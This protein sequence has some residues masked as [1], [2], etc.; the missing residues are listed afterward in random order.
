MVLT[1]SKCS[2]ANPAE[3][4]Y[5]YYDGFVLGGGAARGGPL[6]V[7]AQPFLA[8]FVFPNGR[9]CR[10]FDEMAVACQE[11]WPAARDL[12]AQGFL[13]KF[14]GGLGRLDLALA[15]K[16]AAH[17]PDPDRGL[18]QLLGKLPSN[19]LAEPALRVEPQELNLGALDRSRER[20]FD[21]HLD[22][23]GMRL[24]YGS[25]NASEGWL[26]LGEGEGTSEKHF[27]FTHEQ[28]IPV[29]I[30]L[31]KLRAGTKPI[32]GKLLVESNA[33][34]TVVLVRATVPIKPF[35]EGVLKGA[36]TPRQVAEKAKA[37]PK[38]AA[39]LFEHGA[40]AAWYKDNGWTYPVQ[41]PAASG[42]A[43]V[44]QFFEALGLTKPP[45][46]QISERKIA[47]EGEPGQSLRASLQVSTEE[48]RAVYAHGVSDQPWLEVGRAKLNGRV[49]T[50]Q[51]TIPSVPNRPGEAL[52]AKLT[53]QSNGNQRFVVPVTLQVGGS[54]AA[55]VFD[56]DAMTT[57][58]APTPVVAPPPP[59]VA[60]LAP[61]PTPPP[62]APS[63]SVRRP[64]DQRGGGL[65]RHLVPAAVLL[66]ALAGIVVIDLVRKPSGHG[67]PESR[68]GP[69]LNYAD[70]ADK[71]AY[72]DYV[73][74]TE[75]GQTTYRFGL[76][77][78]KEPDPDNPKEHKRL[79]YRE[80]GVTN[81]TCV[82][83]AGHEYIFG[84]KYSGSSLGRTREDR[85]KHYWATSWT[86][87]EK[88]DVLQ[89]VQIV[90]GAQ[91]GKLD[92]ALV[93]YT[94]HNKGR[95]SPKVGLRVMFD[96]YIGGNDRVPFVIPGKP[97]MVKTFQE[98]KGDAIPDYIEALEKP[99]PQNPGTVAHMGLKGIHVP[100]VTV[101]P[102]D[103]VVLRKFPGADAGWEPPV[104][105][106][107][108][109]LEIDDSCIML[110][111]AEREMDFDEKRYMA[112]SYGLNAISSP[113]G[114]GNLALTAGGSFLVGKDFTVTAYV[115]NPQARETVTLDLP[116]GLS[117]A[118]G[119]Q[120]E[121]EVQAKGEQTQVSWKVVHSSDQE[122]EYMI[123]AHSNK[124][125][126]AGYRVRITKGGLFR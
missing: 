78:T 23:S 40:V 42:K 48:S 49:A 44:Q 18:D 9:T 45:K 46:V 108:K 118:S 47:L 3:A 126:R 70:L 43:A 35:P 65:W 29:R 54:A 21:L 13:E 99:D 124:G 85:E 91:S 12:L 101:E 90:P 62:P 10:S 25:V 15:A 87:P 112:F 2:R 50:L 7:G 67:G 125:A 24:V 38:E 69:G 66:L 20:A 81:N 115:K 119:Q 106:E 123:G 92:T 11:E 63:P 51:F 104:P 41:G 107:V 80:N 110:Y 103:R 84:R 76:I 56:F 86:S 72:L 89:E 95:V 100:D 102:I 31:D 73:P 116:E 93:R 17:F 122:G 19:V 1:C 32:E 68:T 97:G 75:S 120:A 88:V 8:P 52:K 16:E 83:I 94:L 111:W 4:V 96:T 33:G 14:L 5:C 64:R 57:A 113:E 105:E 61:A 114:G 74:S 36:L 109:A 37:S 98:I 59:P 6:A 28:T 82:N 55:S 27:Q 22:N 34:S 117:L 26:A 39:E 60:A 30:R 121:Q 79:T 53:I 71:T 58:P 77:L